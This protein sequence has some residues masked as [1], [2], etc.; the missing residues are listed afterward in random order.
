MALTDKS[1]VTKVLE[2][3]S[4]LAMVLTET[5]IWNSPSAMVLMETSSSAMVLIENQ[6]IQ[7]WFLYGP[8]HWPRG[9]V[10]NQLFGHGFSP[11]NQ[12]GRRGSYMEHSI[13]W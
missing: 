3:P 11:R 5:N 4:L 2:G 9:S 8:L 10:R 6:L 7:P 1:S 12:L 13:G